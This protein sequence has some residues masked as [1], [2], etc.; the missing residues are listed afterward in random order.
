M[1]HTINEIL[2]KYLN[3][4]E[5]AKLHQKEIGRYWAS[6][7]K[8]IRSKKITPENFF[9]PHKIE[10]KGLP[11]V[12]AGMMYE[13]AFTK[14][15]TK[16]K[17]PVQFQVKLEIPLSEEITIIS[18]IDYVFE[19]EGLETKKPLYP[20]NTIP[21]RYKDQLEC[22]FRAL[23]MQMYLGEFTSPFGLR[24]WKYEPN[25]IRWEEI[26]TLLR[27]FDSELRKKNKK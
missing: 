27:E 15:L 10:E 20:L 9:E 8:D 18:V 23:G 12:F 24:R 14:I 1:S 19:K 3:D 13:D 17:S 4:E 25:D 6:A 16:T 21:E 11:I 26:K 2:D 22:E 5:Q 7:I